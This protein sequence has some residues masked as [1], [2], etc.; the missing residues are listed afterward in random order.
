MDPLSIGIIVTV[1]SLGTVL[2]YLFNVDFAKRRGRKT[3]HGSDGNMVTSKK[4]KGKNNP[5]TQS[6]AAVKQQQ[7][8]GIGSPNSKR[9]PPLVA[10]ASNNSG[11]S[12]AKSCPS[13]EENKHGQNIPDLIAGHEPKIQNGQT[14]Q[15]QISN[16]NKN[17][18]KRDTK[19]ANFVEVSQ[20]EP[21]PDELDSSIA[22]GVF[23][24]SSSGAKQTR[25]NKSVSK[26]QSIPFNEE[27]FEGYPDRGGGSASPSYCPEQLFTMIA[28]S[29]LSRDEVEIAVE[30]LLNKIDS[31]DSDWKK[32][33]SD[34]VERLK[35][36]LRES[37]N[38]L[39][40]E[41]QNHEQTR[42]RLAELKNQLQI[43][44][45][46]LNKSEEEMMK[47]KKE[48][49]VA[50]L[51]L[52]QSRVDLSRLQLVLK[53]RSEE[54]SRVIS[55]LE[56]EKMQMQALLTE[57]TTTNGD[58][59]VLRAKLDEK[60][61]QLQRYELSQQKMSERMAELES[62]LRVADHLVDELRASKQ[63]D[64]YEASAKIS[65]LKSDRI[66][67]DKGLKD[68]VTRF[69]EV[70]EANSLLSRT[71]NELKSIN[72]RQDEMLKQMT[73]ERQIHEL[74]MK[75][76]LQEMELELKEL[77]RK[78]NANT[79]PSRQDE[80]VLLRDGI[81]NHDQM[82]VDREQKLI[83]E[84]NQLREGLANLF[85]DAVKPSSDTDGA[86][87]NSWVRSYVVALKQLSKTLDE[88]KEPNNNVKS[89]SPTSPKK[90][91]TTNNRTTLTTPRKKTPS[92][93]NNGRS[94]RGK[95]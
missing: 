45:Q 75:R 58:Q 77:Q 87:T 27:S 82:G 63:H 41:I 56:Q 46:S 94:S 60:L 6:Q 50:N 11:R 33:K 83:S 88:L 22:M 69:K 89:E 81:A 49:G 78:L 93:V 91:L 40:I 14:R 85:P 76:T 30:M 47:L 68:Q 34:P 71:I 59:E 64:D 86:A 26:R 5:T 17:V 12:S 31:G 13:S 79:V 19:Q 21:S 9:S 28:A 43:E 62:K 3:L 52:E 24:Q 53:Q 37:E 20:F 72:S 32:P 18:K 44:R 23:N 65:E 66:Q 7:Q 61:V 95:F 48:L 42:A 4:S 80:K 84:M 15:Q 35:N 38:V 2:L 51:A 8:N 67:L 54:N 73:D 74:S 92:Q 16:S 25:S 36:Q 1:L 10:V 39:A 57:D 55:R 90:P 70:S 29:N